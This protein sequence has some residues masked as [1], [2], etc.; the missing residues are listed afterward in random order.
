M[1]TSTRAKLEPGRYAVGMLSH[2]ELHLNPIQGILHIKPAFQY[3]DKAD[4]NLKSEIKETGA[5][6]PGKSYFI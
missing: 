5:G 3:L 6:E 1:Y 2:Q 4:K